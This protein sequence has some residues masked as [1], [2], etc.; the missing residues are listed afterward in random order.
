MIISLQMA[1][2]WVITNAQRSVPAAAVPLPSPEVKTQQDTPAMLFHWQNI[3]AFSPS[4]V[5]NH[6]GREKKNH[7]F[8]GV[9]SKSFGRA[10]LLTGDSK[11]C[12]SFPTGQSW[13]SWNVCFWWPQPSHALNSLDLPSVWEKDRM[14]GDYAHGAPTWNWWG[15]RCVDE[16]LVNQLVS[17]TEQRRRLS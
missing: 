10:P 13:K 11:L 1:L 3:C 14:S 16:L 8:C 9:D 6:C 5:Q 12:L 4:F 17:V 2:W 7:I 15:V